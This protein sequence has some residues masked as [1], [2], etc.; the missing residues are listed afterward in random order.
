MRQISHSPTQFKLF[1]DFLARRFLRHQH[2]WRVT[3]LLDFPGFS[4]IEVMRGLACFSMVVALLVAR[5]VCRAY[6]DLCDDII[7]HAQRASQF[8]NAGNEIGSNKEVRSRAEVFDSGEQ[9]YC[10]FQ[11]SEEE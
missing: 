7:M 11:R 8:H 6:D 10:C 2:F 1:R 5:V 3:E 4:R 9:R